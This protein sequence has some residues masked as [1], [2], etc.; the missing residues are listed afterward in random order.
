MYRHE[1]PTRL[2]ARSEFELEKFDPEQRP[3]E[4]RVSTWSNV[5]KEGGRVS[6]DVYFDGKRDNLN[7]GEISIAVARR[8]DNEA[9][10]LQGLV[11]EWNEDAAGNWR[12]LI[13]AAHEDLRCYHQRKI[14]E[15][16]ERLA[17]LGV[18]V[19]S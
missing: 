16:S 4:L 12:A 13:L 19:K 7:L 5:F 11:D 1:W 18:E 15:H 2:Q 10:H 3:T 8:V 6:V 14:A 17:A 9:Q